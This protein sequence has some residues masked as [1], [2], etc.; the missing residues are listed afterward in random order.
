[1]PNPDFLFLID[2]G[3]EAW[4]Q[5]RTVH[6]CDTPNLSNAYLFD[7]VLDGFDLSGVNLERACLIGASFQYANL[8]RA[9]LQSAYASSTDF[10]AADL[11]GA[12]LS[13]GVF[14]EANFTQANLQ[15]SDAIGT[16][17]ADAC[18]EK[19][20]MLEWEVDETTV[21]EDSRGAGAQATDE[22]APERESREN[23]WLSLRTETREM[24]SLPLHTISTASVS[25]TFLRRR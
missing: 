10:T 5:W 22:R 18:F 20:R 13:Q 4:N 3:A 2:Q 9:N 25:T 7:C 14:I 11:T 1:M 8:R 16:N 15:W 17:F 19:A 12:I 23:S 21:L 6:P 24:I